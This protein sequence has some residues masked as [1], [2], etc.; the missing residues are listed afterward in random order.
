MPDFDLSSGRVVLVAVGVIVG[1]L[2][3]IFATS[4][5]SVVLGLVLVAIA[6]YVVYIIARGLNA[7]LF[8]WLSGRGGNGGGG[9]GG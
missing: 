4:V 9:G 3:I 6:L 7:R 2:I 8:D 1:G 5:L